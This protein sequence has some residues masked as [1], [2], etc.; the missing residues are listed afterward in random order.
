MGP[1][2]HAWNAVRNSVEEVWETAKGTEVAMGVRN[3][4]KF[5]RKSSVGVVPKWLPGL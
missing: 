2:R 4:P 1:A 3:M 5:L